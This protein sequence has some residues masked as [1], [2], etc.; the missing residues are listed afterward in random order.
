M[1]LVDGFDKL[2]ASEVV[3]RPP[4]WRRRAT[5]TFRGPKQNV[6]STTALFPLLLSLLR[7]FFFML[8]LINLIVEHASI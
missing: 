1:L 2:R 8:D 3:E 4:D 7:I 5:K 6:R